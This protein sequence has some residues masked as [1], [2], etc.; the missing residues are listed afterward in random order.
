MSI[1]VAL[2]HVTSYLYDRPVTLG[3]QKIRLRPAPHTR[4]AIQSYS[5][6]I[7]PQQHFINWQQDPFGN[8]LARVDFPEK[9]R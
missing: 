9:L 3:T 7:T 5:L 8:F 2:K 1:V 6:K 4:N